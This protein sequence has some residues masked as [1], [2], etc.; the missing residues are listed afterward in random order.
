M[1]SSIKNSHIALFGMVAL[2]AHLNP[3]IANAISIPSAGGSGNTLDVSWKNIVVWILDLLVWT[4]AAIGI[5]CII[6]SAIRKAQGEQDA[7]R[8]ALGGIVSVIIAIGSDQIGTT[9]QGIV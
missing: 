1:R 7:K 5:G 8:W 2:F 4:T 3:E 9:I 6:F